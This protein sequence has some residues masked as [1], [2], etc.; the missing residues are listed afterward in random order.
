VLP[1]DKFVD[2]PDEEAFTVAPEPLRGA[3]DRSGGAV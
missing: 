1:R 2:E 3:I